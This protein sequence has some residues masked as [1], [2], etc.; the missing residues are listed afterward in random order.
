M[1]RNKFI[2]T[3]SLGC[4]GMTTIGSVMQGCSS[5]KMI[6]STLEGDELIL[7]L[8]EFELIKKEKKSFYPFIIIQN[9]QLKYPIA[10]YRFGDSDYSVM[11]MRCTHQGTELRAFGSKLQCPAHGS[12]FGNRGSVS[13]GPASETLRHFP[14][15][16]T[17]EQ[18]IIKLK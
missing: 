10:V 4:I 15:T 16:L 18:L 12:E 11:L 8:S 7:A 1:K 9:A 14:F 5:S 2:K 6:N 13:N 3:C 17:P